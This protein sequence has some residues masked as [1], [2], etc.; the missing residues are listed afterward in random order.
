MGDPLSP[1]LFI[2]CAK[3]LSRLIETRVDLGV[4]MVLGSLQ[5]LKLSLIS[6]SQMTIPYFFKVKP[7]K[8]QEIRYLLMEYAQASGK[9]INQLQQILNLL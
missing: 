7:N 3:A 5:A 6:F 4:F 2:I 1:Y 8:V 9:V